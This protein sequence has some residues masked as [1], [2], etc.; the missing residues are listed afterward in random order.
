MSPEQLAEISIDR[1]SK[2]LALTETSKGVL[3]ILL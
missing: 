2:I 1:P 3:Q